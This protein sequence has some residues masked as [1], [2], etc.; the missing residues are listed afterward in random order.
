MFVF[1]SGHPIGI[2]LHAWY[3]KTK[4]SITSRFRE[5]LSAGGNTIDFVLISIRNQHRNNI[6]SEACL[7]I[8]YPVL[9]PVTLHP[10]SRA[11]PSESLLPF[12]RTFP[13]NKQTLSRSFLLSSSSPW[14]ALSLKKW[15]PPPH[16]YKQPLSHFSHN[17]ATTQRLLRPHHTAAAQSPPQ[18]QPQQ[19]QQ[20]QHHHHHHQQ[21]R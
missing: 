17:H 13:N 9:S 21:E 8:L 19:Q 18:P 20:Q 7:S 1:V 16:K 4:R 10:A 2:L 15:G 6:R 5:L 3:C 11:S 12:E 14:P